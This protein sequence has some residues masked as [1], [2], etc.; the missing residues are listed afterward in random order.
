MVS[1]GHGAWVSRQRLA[2]SI[3]IAL[4]AWT[5]AF[6]GS[7]SGLGAVSAG[8]TPADTDV[9][10][11]VA[12]AGQAAGHIGHSCGI[13][14]D[15]S[16]WC[17]GPNAAGQLGLGDVDGRARPVQVGSDDD[18]VQVSVSWSSTCGVRE[19]G[20]LWCWGKPYGDLPQRVGVAS[21][22]TSVNVGDG[23]RCG[24]QEDASLWCW[25]DNESGQLGL[26]DRQ[27]RGHPTQVGTD[28]DWQ[29]VAT[30]G[31]HTCAVRSEGTL[32]CWGT[33]AQGQLGLGQQ[34]TALEPAR[35]GAGTTWSRVSV[36][37]QDSCATRQHHSAWCW[38][39]NKSGQ[40][41]TGDRVDYDVPT[42]VVSAE[43]W[44]RIDVGT[45]HACGVRTDSTLWCWGENGSGQLGVGGRYGYPFPVQVR[46]R[47]SWTQSA[48]GAAD[49]CGVES[50]HTLWCWG[51]PDGG[52]LGIGNRRDNTTVPTQVGLPNLPVDHKA[53]LT[54]ISAR[55]ADD[56]WAVGYTQ[57]DDKQHTL[58]EHWDGSAWTRVPSVDP[59]GRINRLLGVTAL[60]PDDV[61][62]VGTTGVQRVAQT[63]IE[64]WDGSA[65][66]QVPSPQGP[67]DTSEL[68]SVA[69]ASPTD[70]WAVGMGDG[71]QFEFPDVVLE[72]WDG[73]AWSFVSDHTSWSS[74]QLTG[75]TA[76]SSRNVWA[77]GYGLL[78]YEYG[79]LPISLHWN[80]TSW[81][82][83]AIKYGDVSDDHYLRSVDAT[84]A[85]DLWAA[86]DELTGGPR[87][88]RLELHTAGRWTRVDSPNLGA[89]SVY[90]VS[91]LADDDVWAVGSGDD[92]RQSFTLHW[93]GGTWQAVDAPSRNGANTLF[94]VSNIAADD[95]WAVGFSGPRSSQ[96]ILIEHW[97]GTAW[98]ILDPHR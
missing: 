26:G 34:E 35:V 16:L 87:A 91:A 84:P 71:Q 32:W 73:S 33:G 80:G 1:P 54:A 79:Y 44:E 77:V 56:V 67:Y 98:T 60:A 10:S 83:V 69:A 55:S 7:S 63:L 48:A 94:G 82:Q 15:G 51:N 37:V 58:V 70:I 29:L 9:W 31:T 12:V 18:W 11:S 96:R 40:L 5:L 93:D 49:S 61:W 28:L 89:T 13:Q 4:A 8:P 43:T 20:T 41:G 30:G 90:G 6:A 64:H 38:G 59:G 95:A 92:G 19:D 74:R 65:W 85:G 72:H 52:E 47:S 46:P 68:R 57:R 62:A 50:D 14:V 3:V 21:T 2:S 25:G 76:L 53:I 45:A 39:D 22:W 86:G 88:S 17:W 81:R 24:V 97:D 42:K 36:G 75:V 66:S 27:R 23:Y 78:D